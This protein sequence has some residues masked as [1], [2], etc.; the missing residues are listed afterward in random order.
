[1]GIL[2]GNPHKEPLHYGE[3]FGIWSYVMM[4]KANYASYQTFIN[5][6]GDEDLQKILGDC[7]S[8]INQEYE[9]LE[10]ILKVNGISIPPSPPERSYADSEN[11]PIGA[12][13]QDKEISGA[14]SVN[15]A[16][17]LVSCSTI[18]GE[19][20][21]EDIAMLFGQFHTNQAQTAA[22][23]LRLN[24]EKGWLITPPLHTDIPNV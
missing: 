13:F 17:C 21:R 15:I 18:M 19:S 3:V 2:S 24:K 23:L 16:K 11:I 9:R 1:M 20:I 12:K 10:E 7:I 22:K 5:H 6:C 8:Q 14:I 4:G